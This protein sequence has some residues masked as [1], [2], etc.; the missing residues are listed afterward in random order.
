MASNGVKFRVLGALYVPQLTTRR[1]SLLTGHPHLCA[2]WSLTRHCCAFPLSVKT[3]RACVGVFFFFSV[4]WGVLT[5]SFHTLWKSSQAPKLFSCTASAAWEGFRRRLLRR[6]SPAAC[7]V[8][9]S[10]TT[11]AGGGGGGACGGGRSKLSAR[12]I[13]GGVLHT[14]AVRTDEVVVT[15]GALGATTVV[16]RAVTC[17]A[18]AGTRDATL[19]ALLLSSRPRSGK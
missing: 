16:G 2:E 11:G 1:T 7:S 3:Q 15:S 10:S 9:L 5:L 12:G 19:L 18:G 17:D 13:G 8:V 14:R 4:C 6:S